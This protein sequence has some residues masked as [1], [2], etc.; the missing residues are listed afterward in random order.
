MP[1]REAGAANAASPSST[2]LT[3]SLPEAFGSPLPAAPASTVARSSVTVA[4]TTIE[5]ASLAPVMATTMLWLAVPSSEL[6][7]S[8][9]LTASPWLS[10]CVAARLL[11]SV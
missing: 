8:V 6:T 3:V 5:A 11:S 4:S 1:L 2:S 9:S 7:L 10:A